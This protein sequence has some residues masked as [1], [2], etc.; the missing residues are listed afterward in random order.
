VNESLNNGK[1]LLETGTFIVIRLKLTKKDRI[2]LFIFGL[3]VALYLITLGQVLPAVAFWLIF[4][5]GV[6]LK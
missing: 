3:S 6:S 5:L 2:F 1:G 4:W